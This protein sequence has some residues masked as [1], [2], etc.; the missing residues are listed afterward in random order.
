[1]SAEKVKPSEKSIV[2][3]KSEWN[4]ILQHMKRGED[5]KIAAEADREYKKYLFEESRAMTDKWENSL[6]ATIKARED[7]RLKV[8]RQK[9]DEAAQRFQKLKESDEMKRFEEN[10][11]AN[12]QMQKLKMGPRLLESAYATSECVAVRDLQRNANAKTEQMK[13]DHYLASGREAVA[14]DEQYA[15]QQKLIMLETRRKKDDYKKELREFIENKER[16]DADLRKAQAEKERLEH[17]QIDSDLAAQ[18]SKER[19][20]LEKKKEAKRIIAL[21]AMQLAEKRR[22]R[23]WKLFRLLKSVSPSLVF[24]KKII[25]YISGEKQQEAL[26]NQVAS[27]FL[28]GNVINDVKHRNDKELKRGKDEFQ[29]N[30][31]KTALTDIKNIK[32]QEEAII[33][34]SV[35][36][37]QAKLKFKDQ[38]KVEERRR[39][40][41]LQIK[42]HLD[43]L[44]REKI[45]KQ[46][47]EI[48]LKR[49]IEN[50][51]RNEEV[52]VLFDRQKRLETL[53]RVKEHRRIITEQIEE[54]HQRE[55][56]KDYSDLICLNE[57]N[58][59][60]DKAFFKYANELVNETI[61]KERSIYPIVKVVED[62]QRTNNVQSKKLIYGVDELKALRP[63]K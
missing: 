10:I 3:H 21:E 39:L 26:E 50:R 48:E 35:E 16:Q 61:E 14:Q 28:D 23:K 37:F 9:I 25:F 1:M 17:C 45:R 43:D 7:E 57:M 15:E 54:R 59:Q 49:D 11:K 20:V 2:L 5:V 46:R 4:G 53:T 44:A 47:Q 29:S 42:N 30:A 12:E 40:K 34:R 19:R 41:Q 27:L 33:K 36:E 51:I 13:R 22:I 18:M 8:E 56:E 24:N 52:N 32:S 62:Y 55:L 6:K 58:E 38:A 31:W 60:E 63:Q